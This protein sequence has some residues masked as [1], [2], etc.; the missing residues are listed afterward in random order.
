[1]DKDRQLGCERHRGSRPRWNLAST[2]RWCPA[3]SPGRII[4]PRRVNA[5]M[6]VSITINC[7]RIVNV[8]ELWMTARKRGRKAET[9]RGEVGDTPMPGSPVRILSSAHLAEGEWGELSDFEFGLIVAYN[10]F[11]RWAVRCMAAAGMPDLTITD[12]LVLHH[13]HHRGRSKKLADVCFTLSYEDT[14]VVNYSLK[15]L[16]GL[17]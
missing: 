6:L 11:S 15:K 16:L 2:A 14:H 3:P 8:L 5:C 17:G 12:V 9:N 13:V 1:R 4:T 7:Q 10:A